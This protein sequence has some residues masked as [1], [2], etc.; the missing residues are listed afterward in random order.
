MHGSSLPAVRGTCQGR[1]INGRE[2]FRMRVGIMVDS[3]SAETE[4]Q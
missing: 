4:K 3:A 1:A 2:K